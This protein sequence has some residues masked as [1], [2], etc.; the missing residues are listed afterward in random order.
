MA[1]KPGCFAI[2]RDQNLKSRDLEEGVRQEGVHGVADAL[3]FVWATLP[4]CPDFS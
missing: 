1:V 2:R 4:D 3:D